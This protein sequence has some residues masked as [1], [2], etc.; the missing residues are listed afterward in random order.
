MAIP[1]TSRVVR[2]VPLNV[3]PNDLNNPS[4]MSSLPQLRQGSIGPAVFCIGNTQI[5]Q[6]YEVLIKITERGCA[7]MRCLAGRVAPK[8]VLIEGGNRFVVD[9]SSNNQVCSSAAKGGL[10]EEVTGTRLYSITAL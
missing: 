10:L 7:A 9:P 6:Y 1:G 8:E 2:W 5:H 3:V 4:R